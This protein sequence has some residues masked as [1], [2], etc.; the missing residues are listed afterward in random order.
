MEWK[1]NNTN[2]INSECVEGF[3]GHYAVLDGNKFCIS[4]TVYYSG[5]TD[6]NISCLKR[7]LEIDEIIYYYIDTDSNNKVIWGR[8][9]NNNIVALYLGEMNVVIKIYFA[10]EPMTGFCQSRLEEIS[11][12]FLKGYNVISVPVH[13]WTT[14]FCTTVSVNLP[15]DY[16]KKIPL[17]NYSNETSSQIKEL[18][19]I[20]VAENPKARIILLEG[21]PGTGKTFYIKRLSALLLKNNYYNKK[22]YYFLAKGVD[23]LDITTCLGRNIIVLEDA[24][25]I[26]GGGH[27]R[28][29]ELLKILNLSSGFIDVNSI[30]IFTSNL[31]IDSIDDAFKRDGRLLAHVHFSRLSPVDARRWLKKYYGCMKELE[32]KGYTLA[33]LYSIAGVIPRKVSVFSNKVLGFGRNPFFQDYPIR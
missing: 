6:E 32:Q 15:L 26:L 11:R 20:V 24:D 12:F 5:P 10:H 23:N 25:F 14:R 33:E 30:F 8:M 28:G 3:L 17:D 2:N 7:I 27:S 1:Y 9:K 22:L 29:K 4:R 18:E 13:C 16:D 21:P 19:K 31:K